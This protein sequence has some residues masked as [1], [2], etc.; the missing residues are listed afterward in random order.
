M[1]RMYSSLGRS[2]NSGSRSVPTTLSS[3]SRAFG[4]K[5]GP[6][7]TQARRKLARDPAVCRGISGWPWTL[8]TETDRFNSS[9][10]WGACS[11]GNL[12]VCHAEVCL[13][14]EEM[15][16][17]AFRGLS[18]VHL[19]SDF[20]H[21]LRV[22]LDVFSTLLK[23]LGFPRSEY[24]RDV[25][26]CWIPLDSVISGNATKIRRSEVCSDMKAGRTHLTEV[27]RPMASALPCTTV[28]VLTSSTRRP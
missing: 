28:S 14:L 26:E 5:Y 19:L 25:L 11:V 18:A 12:E 15:S 27:R 7:L 4:M 10:E 3:S 17:E 23:H 13:L 22:Q 6:N 2:E 21:E 16:G 9:T 24:G 1:A 8:G 20:V